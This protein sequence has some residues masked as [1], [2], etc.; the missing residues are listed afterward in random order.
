[1]KYN[2]KAKNQQGK[3]KEGV[4]EALRQQSAVEILQKNDLVPLVIEEVKEVSP[5]MKELNRL[6]EGASQKELSIFFRQMATLIE[7]KVPIIQSLM[8]IEEQTE[9]KYL[10]LPLPGNPAGHP[11]GG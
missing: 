10:R 6:W 9:N 11:G 1:M 8:A 4:I 3:V 5:I 2:F 7:A